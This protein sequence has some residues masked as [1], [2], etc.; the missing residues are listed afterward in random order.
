MGQ[1]SKCLLKLEGTG[2]ESKGFYTLTVQRQAEGTWFVQ[3]G[4]EKALRRPHCNLP[5]F[6]RRLQT[7]EKSTLYTDR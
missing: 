7:E 2:N 3:S 4:E 5:I 6:K 1:G